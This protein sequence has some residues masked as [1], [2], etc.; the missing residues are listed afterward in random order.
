MTAEEIP[1]T[2]DTRSAELVRGKLI[3]RPLYGWRHAR[4][5]AKLSRLLYAFVESAKQ[6]EVGSLCGMIVARNPDTVRAPD[7]SFVSAGRLATASPTGFF[8]GAPDIA[9]EVLSPEDRA[10]EIQE[11]TR[12]YLAAGS[13]VVWIVDPQ[14]ETVTVQ[15][16]SGDAHVYSGADAISG[17]DLLPGFSFRPIDLFRQE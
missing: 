11:K 1:L 16:P 6:G 15:Q 9:V 14:T 2:A 7:V 17:E 12:E 13:R 4:T 10:S 5:V 8:S 3:G